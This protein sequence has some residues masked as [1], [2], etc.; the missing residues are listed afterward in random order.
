MD[1]ENKNT[2]P[3]SNETVKSTESE[4]KEVPKTEEVKVETTK[5]VETKTAPKA[6]KP[7]K[8]KKVGFIVSIIIIILAII[9]GAVGGAVY[10]IMFARTEVDLAKYV[11]IEFEGFEGYASFDEDDLVVD[12]KGLKKLLEDKK[13]A[14]KLEEKLLDKAEVKENE[15][16]KNGDEI[17]VKFKVSEEWLKE[18]KIKFTSDTIKLKV[19][20]NSQLILCE[21]IT[22]VY[23]DM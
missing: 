5:K 4:V 17:E 19:K 12:Q 23:I 16:V 20:D 13:L 15:S 18:N 2:N 7:K 21:V 1:E 8:K 6:E 22:G 14:S 10:A 11:T 3:T 9:A